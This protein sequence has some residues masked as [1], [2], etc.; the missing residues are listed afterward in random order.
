MV[1]YVTIETF[2]AARIPL[3]RLL[4]RPAIAVFSPLAVR[5]GIHWHCKFNFIT[6]RSN[7]PIWTTVIFWAV[8]VDMPSGRYCQPPELKGCSVAK[9]FQACFPSRSSMSTLWSSFPQELLSL[10]LHS[11]TLRVRVR[12]YQAGCI[13]SHLSDCNTSQIVIKLYL[14]CMNFTQ[15]FTSQRSIQIKTEYSM[16]VYSNSLKPLNFCSCHVF[17]YIEYLQWGVLE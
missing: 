14:E 1:E 17:I 3:N 4:F 13:T 7:G 16:S 15:N 12:S 6:G 8:V 5:K 2:P 10:P 9:L 11:D